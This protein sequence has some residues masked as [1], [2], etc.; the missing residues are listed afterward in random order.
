MAKIMIN[1][2]WLEFDTARKPVAEMLAVENA[3]GVNYGKFEQDLQA[4]SARALC[5]FIW[6]VWRR[7][8]R[9]VAFADIESGAVEIDLE[10]CEFPEPEQA[11]PTTGPGGRGASTGTAANTSR[12]SAKSG[13]G[14]GK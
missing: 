13:S 1:G 8:G 12:R 6:L 2:E 14:P 4:G 11:D 7:N 10:N 3:L 5:A 9:D